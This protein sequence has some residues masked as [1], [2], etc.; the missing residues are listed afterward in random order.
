MDAAGAIMLIGFSALL[1]FNQVVI[2]VVN[3]GLQPVFFAGLRSVG[4][5]FCL[6]L[7][8]SFRGRPPVLRGDLVWPGILS[9]FVFAAEFT[10]L[11]VALDLTTV[12][13]TSVIFYSMPVWLAI[14]GHLL[15][16]GERITRAKAAGLLVAFGGVAWAILDRGAGG[17]AGSLAGDLCALGAAIGWASIVLV[18]RGTGLSRL[19]PEMQMF[20]QVLV[21]APLLLGAAVFFGPLLRDPAPIH[22]LGLGFQI[23]VVVAAGFVFWFWL[24]SIYPAA[25]VASFSFLSPIFGFAFGWL[26]LGEE[27]GWGLG[28]ALLLVAAGLVLINRPAAQ[29]PQKV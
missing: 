16:E 4:A 22:F 8:M 23:V 3:E 17:G 5:A 6:W 29:V 13:R 11:F 1:G 2:K 9:G 10:L 15:L 12:T 28:G 26:I 18:V 20:W 24:L 21:S 25:G 27:I 7:W 19:H 14:G